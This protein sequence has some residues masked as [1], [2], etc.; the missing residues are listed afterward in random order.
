MQNSQK[1]PIVTEVTFQGRI[2]EEGTKLFMFKYSAFVRVLALVEYGQTL[3][4]VVEHK[5]AEFVRELNAKN[6]GHFP[7]YSES[8]EEKNQYYKK[9]HLEVQEEVS[10]FAGPLVQN[11]NTDNLIFVGTKKTVIRQIAECFSITE[12]FFVSKLIGP[13]TKTKTAIPFAAFLNIFFKDR[14]KD[15]DPSFAASIRKASE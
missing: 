2:V 7:S 3:C 13:G 8:L 6:F 15:F 14:R 5:E 10:F 9:L 1:A 12:G 4:V 11:P